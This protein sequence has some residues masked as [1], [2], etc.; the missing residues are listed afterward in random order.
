MRTARV[1]AWLFIITSLPLFA[2]AHTLA[3][4][5]VDRVAGLHGTPQREE[6][7]KLLADDTVVDAKAFPSTVFFHEARLRAPLRSLIADPAVGDKARWL[8]ALIGNPEDV[9]LLV[10][11]DPKGRRRHPHSDWAYPVVCDLLQP[12]SESEWIFLRKC[13][14]NDYNDRWVERGA[15]QTLKLIA[16]KRSRQILEEAAKQGAR[17]F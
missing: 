5:E 17:R 3:N 10:R 9:R 4:S 12:E 1:P 8:L 2:C 13:A 7:R 11:L 15:I 6:L 14:L 16:S